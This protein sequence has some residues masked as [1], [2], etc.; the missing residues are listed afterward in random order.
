MPLPIKKTENTALKNSIENTNSDNHI[1]NIEQDITHS[2]QLLNELEQK[3]NRRLGNTTNDAKIGVN[4]TQERR[5]EEGFKKVGFYLYP[6]T[7]KALKWMFGFDSFRKK[8]KNYDELFNKLLL[9]NK[10]FQTF[11]NMYYEHGE[12]EELLSDD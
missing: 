2:S 7:Y 4:K 8:Y 3:I 9:E 12:M 1:D 6:E 11:L 10:D 5:K